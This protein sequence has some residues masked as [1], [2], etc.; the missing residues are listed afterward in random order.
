MT[1][2]Q[3]HLEDLDKR[4]VESR[5]TADL[6][7]DPAVRLQNENLSEYLLD[8]ARRLREQL[9]TLNTI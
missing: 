9:P 1:D 2:F 8:L 6:A 3:R 4:A 5:L 7:T